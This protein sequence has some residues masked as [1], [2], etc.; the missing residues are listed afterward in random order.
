MLVLSRADRR[1]AGAPVEPAG[2]PSRYELR[3]A[4]HHHLVC[5]SCG[6]TA[7]VDCL[8]GGAPCFEP[9][10]AHGYLVDE[11]E[12]TFWGSCPACR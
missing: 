3:V 10:A 5:H 8:V 11:A 2:S 12:V 4:D 6:A 1:R 7:D 9:S